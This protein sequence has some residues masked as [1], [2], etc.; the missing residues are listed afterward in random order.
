MGYVDSTAPGQAVLVMWNEDVKFRRMF[1][2]EFMERFGIRS[3]GDAF[4][5][6]ITDGGESPRIEFERLGNVREGGAMSYSEV[7]LDISF[8]PAHVGT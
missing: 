1:P 3:A 4:L 2:L 5:A 8:V 6:R 7:V